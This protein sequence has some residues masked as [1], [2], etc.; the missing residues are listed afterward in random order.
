MNYL[1]TRKLKKMKGTV[2]SAKLIRED[3]NDR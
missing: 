2:S 3:R 1:A